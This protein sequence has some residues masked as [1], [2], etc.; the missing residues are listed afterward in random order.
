[1]SHAIACL[2]IVFFRR[3]LPP[4]E[5][6]KATAPLYQELD[7]PLFQIAQGLVSPQSLPGGAKGIKDLAGFLRRQSL[8]PPRPL[9]KLHGIG[10]P[11]PFH[12]LTNQLFVQHHPSPPLFFAIGTMSALISV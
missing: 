2:R 6:I 7:A 11:M 4:S 5:G 10:D 8:Q 3:P 12:Q 9:P 1:L